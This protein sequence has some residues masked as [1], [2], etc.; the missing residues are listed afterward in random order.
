MDGVLVDTGQLHYQSW[1]EA[2][3]AIGVP[4][5]FHDFSA[6]FGMNN[7]SILKLWLGSDAP[8]ALIDRIGDQKEQIFRRMAAGQALVLP[9]VHTLLEALRRA[10]VRQAVGSS[11]PQA[12]IDVLL[13]AGGLRPYFEAVVSAWDMP[14]KPDPAVFLEAAARLGMPPARCVV[15]E[16]STAGIEAARRAGMQ[17]IAVTNTHPAAML[18]AASM[19][20]AS[21]EEVTPEVVAG[22]IEN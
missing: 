17:C 3:A 14:G 2:L 7:T 22:L 10:G 16:D 1:A 13:A 9:G 18:S 11:A 6:T 15:I 21:L 19:V 5:S 8:Q 4:L 20:V 12:N